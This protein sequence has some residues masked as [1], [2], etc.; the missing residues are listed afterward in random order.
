MTKLET[1]LIPAW[2]TWQRFGTK[3]EQ[4]F[5]EHI[6][7]KRLLIVPP[8]RRHVGTM[9]ASEL[10]KS[11][12]KKGYFIFELKDATG[13]T[14][15]VHEPDLIRNKK[16]SERLSCPWRDLVEPFAGGIIDRETVEAE[17]IFKQPI[18]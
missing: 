3:N 1:V 7:N 11:R 12:R 9:F 5:N 15:M 10:K 4:Y 18:K 2:M 17:S 14:W 16:E 13:E 8:V 6:K